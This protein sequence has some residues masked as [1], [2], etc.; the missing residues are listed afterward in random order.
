MNLVFISVILL[1]IL[2]PII[3]GASL[4]MLLSFIGRIIFLARIIGSV[5]P[6]RVCMIFEAAH[7]FFPVLGLIMNGG[8]KDWVG[9]L[10]NIAICGVV[11]L[12]YII[13]NANYL[14]VFED[15]DGDDE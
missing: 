14:Y 1:T 11:C 12:I 10:L 5:V 7:L 3:C 13:D 15:D 4:P 9:F 6:I 8:V 2:Q